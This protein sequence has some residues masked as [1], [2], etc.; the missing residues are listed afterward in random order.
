MAFT[1]LTAQEVLPEEPTKSELFDKI[2]LDLDDV[3]TRLIALEATSNTFAP[4]EFGFLGKFDSG[5]V[6]DGFS[7]YRVQQNITLLAVRLLI[8][9]AGSAG[10]TQVDIQRR[11][12]GG[13]WASVLTA[14]LS[15]GFGSGNF[16]LTSGTIAIA[17]IL[18]GEILRADLKACQTDV[19]DF[20]V[21]AEYAGA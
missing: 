21:Y 7:H 20:Y 3:N 8:I 1:S 9:T 14:V 19:Q 18:Q 10:T 13:V 12:A 17:S 11:T 5:D 2:R 4:I 6:R 15:A 16:F